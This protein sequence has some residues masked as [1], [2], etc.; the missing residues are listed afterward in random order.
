M[1][2]ETKIKKQPNLKH[3]ILWTI[4][5]S[6]VAMLVLYYF[7][8]I[9]PIPAVEI[10]ATGI[11]QTKE[12]YEQWYLKKLIIQNSK[13]PKSELEFG[14]KI[15]NFHEI[16]SY[17]FI[18]TSSVFGKNIVH[19]V[20]DEYDYEKREFKYKQ[21]SFPVSGNIVLGFIKPSKDVS[22][23][24]KGG[25]LAVFD[26][27]R[28][29][30]DYFNINGKVIYNSHLPKDTIIEN[31]D[32]YPFNSYISSK[33]FF[34][35]DIFNQKYSKYS[36][37]LKS[38]KYC[39]LGITDTRDY[40][41]QKLLVIDDYNAKAYY[42]SPIPDLSEPI[43]E[44]DLKIP[45]E[46]IGILCK[47]VNSKDG[48]Y[49]L[50]YNTVAFKKN[51]NDIN[52]SFND[53]IIPLKISR[54]VEDNSVINYGNNY[55]LFGEQYNDS[56]L[57]KAI[58]YRYNL[59]MFKVQNNIIEREIVVPGIKK[60]TSKYGYVI[61]TDKGLFATPRSF[62]ESDILKPKKFQFLKPLYYYPYKSL[63][64]CPN[65]TYEKIEEFLDTDL[66]DLAEKWIFYALGLLLILG[67][68]IIYNNK[69]RHDKK[70]AD[71]EYYK[72]DDRYL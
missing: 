43:F 19:I 5:I 44:K 60:W 64:N 27:K 51:Q 11:P 68:V 48:L 66:R 42:P 28:E 52:Y 9:F 34:I 30:V 36:K 24:F 71:V 59:G 16:S 57:L 41:N 45:F 14:E 15:L 32:S 25:E 33:S 72:Q 63:F 10:D 23:V 35:I 3:V 62:Y 1:E 7:S 69:D 29:T 70:V 20:L 37:P 55:I 56:Y 2:Q 67:L 31:N 54:R 13:I 46:R 12:E 17:E 22:G 61:Y 49:Y 8:Y 58:S 65:F 39:L 4:L 21:F 6:V 18:Y 40:E 50:E 47:F 38:D 26:R 53:Q